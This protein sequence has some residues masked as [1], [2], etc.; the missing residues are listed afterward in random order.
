MLRRLL[1]LL[2]IVWAL[3]FVGFAA[4]QPQ[5][6]PMAKSDGIIVLTGG[7]GRIARGLELLRAGAAPRMLISG[8]DPEV[9]PG[10]LAAEYKIGAALLACC[11]TLGYDSVDTRSNARESAQWIARHKLHRVRLVTSDWHMRRAAWELRQTIPADVELTEDAVHT[12]PSLGILFAEYSKYVLR[13]L[14]HIGKGYYG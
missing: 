10:E 12:R 5:P 4:F 1:A 11:I 3:G 14:W 6:A 9:K 7:E 8:V 2:L 13:R